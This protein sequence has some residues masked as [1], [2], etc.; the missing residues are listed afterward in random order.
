M[1][2]TYPE[3]RRSDGWITS[4]G[5]V[6][7]LPH[8]GAACAGCGE[9]TCVGWQHRG[10]SVLDYGDMRQPV[11]VEMDWLLCPNALGLVETS[12]RSGCTGGT[13]LFGQ[14]ISRLQY[15]GHQEA[16]KRAQDEALQAYLDQIGQL[17]LD[18]D[19][20]LRKESKEIEEVRILAQAR[21]FTV[22]ARLDGA[23]KGDVIQFAYEA[24]LIAGDGRILNLSGASLREA[25]LCPMPL[26][27]CARWSRRGAVQCSSC[28]PT[29]RP[30]ILSS[31]P[32]RGQGAV[33]ACRAAY[34]RGTDRG[35]RPSALHGDGRGRSQLLQA[36]QLPPVELTAMTEALTQAEDLQKDS[37]LTLPLAPSRTRRRFCRPAC[38]P[39]Y[40]PFYVCHSGRADQ[41]ETKDNLL[42]RSH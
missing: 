30:S 17:F 6:E 19:R 22:L 18:K 21:T 26:A 34:L 1:L 11:R 23:C 4:T 20:P 13:C 33:T 10:P 31:K 7:G 35:G 29:R 36:L 3:G 15:L 5:R 9:E 8:C 32:S 39:I 27:G 40:K 41:R 12:S 28:R 14:R 42:F 16:K 24:G 2:H 25:Y 37:V 38:R